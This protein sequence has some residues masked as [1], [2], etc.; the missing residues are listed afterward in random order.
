M[1][2]RITLD[3]P[4][5]LAKQITTIATQQQQSLED[6]LLT[7]IYQALIDILQPD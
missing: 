3:L 1:T 7:L 5:N 2:Y 6:S 4:E